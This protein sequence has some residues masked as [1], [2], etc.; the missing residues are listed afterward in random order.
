MSIHIEAKQG[1]VADK[2]LLPGDP[3]RA[4]FVAENFLQNAECYNNIRGM[5]GFTG[6]YKGIKVSVQG[7]GM[8]QP[9]LSIYVN[10]L[11]K[12]YGVRKAIRI[13][14]AGA[15]QKEIPLKSV[16]LAMSASTDSGINVHR[17]RGCQYAPTADWNLLKNAYDHAEKM[18]VKPLVGSIAS[19]DVFYDDLDIW[20]LWAD[21]GSL[22]IEMETAEL[23]TLAAK[24]G[25]AALAILTI[26]D[27]M[28]THEATSAEER[29]VSFKSM[30]EI[31]LEAII[32]D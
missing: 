23:Y 7:T 27:N 17:F 30:M 20:K 15:L 22:A 26:S 14:T 11:F 24:Y 4:K 1:E 8:G 32:K 28:I 5:L 29:Q 19:S 12:E 13:G 16:V 3:L 18:G 6:T 9:S 21:Y 31:A 25:T 10:E 2:I